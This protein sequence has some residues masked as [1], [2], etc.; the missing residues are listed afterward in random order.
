MEKRLIQKNKKAKF[1]YNILDTYETGIKLIGSEVKS[2]RET[3]VNLK[4]SFCKFFK[5]ELFLFDCHI[6]KYSHHNNSFNE[7]EEKRNRKLLLKKKELIKLEEKLKLN[8][9]LTIVPLDIYFNENNICKLTIGLAE[10]KKLH[11]KRESQKEKD[12]KKKLN[13]KD[14]S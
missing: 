11:D 12:I 14:Y 4:G 6:S 1:D 10:G 3:K 5:G 7:F 2:I 9:G 8:Q 13:Q